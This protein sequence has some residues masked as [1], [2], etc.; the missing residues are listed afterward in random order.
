MVI[1]AGKQCPEY[2]YSFV[3]LIKNEI[4]DEGAEYEHTGKDIEKN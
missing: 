4:N 1:H 3:V 2:E